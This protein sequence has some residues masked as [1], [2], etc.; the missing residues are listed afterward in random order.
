LPLETGTAFHSLGESVNIPIV[1]AARPSQ[2]RA[3]CILS[4]LA[5]LHSAAVL[6][7]RFTNCV[8]S[9]WWLGLATSLFLWPLVLAIHPGRSILRFVLPTIIAA[10][11]FIP[12]ASIYGVLIPYSIE[13]ERLIHEGR[14]YRDKHNAVSDLQPQWLA[15]DKLEKLLRSAPRIILY[16]IDQDHTKPPEVKKGYRPVGAD[17]VVLPDDMFTDSREIFS[18]ADEVPNELLVPVGRTINSIAEETV[19]SHYGKIWL[20]L[21]KEPKQK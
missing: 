6:G 14:I 15:A 20:I 21:R 16:S 10:A 4:V 18:R 13:R 9:W 11:L 19:R 2:I 17:E 3:Y 7:L 1:M 5:I 12:C 8:W